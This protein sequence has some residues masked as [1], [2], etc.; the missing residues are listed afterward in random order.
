MGPTSHRLTTILKTF[1]VL[2]LFLWGN[3]V[4]LAL[5]QTPGA[6]PPPLHVAE[7]SFQETFVS[8]NINCHQGYAWDG[9]NHYGITTGQLYK[10]DTNWNLVASNMNVFAN[11]PSLIHLGDGDYYNGTLYIVAEDWQSCANYTNQSIVTYNSTT[12][13]PL[14]QYDV[15][16]DAHEVSGLCVVPQSG[17][18]GIIY[19][20]SYC[21]G[22]RIWEYD[23][24]T[25][26]L[27]GT[28]PL[29]QDLLGLQGICSHN[30]MF[31]LSQDGGNIYSMDTNGNVAVIYTSNLSGSHEGLKYVDGAIRIL[32]DHGTGHKC[33]H[34]IS[35]KC[36]LFSCPVSATGWMV[37]GGSTLAGPW[38]SI[39][40][41]SFVTNGAILSMVTQIPQG[42]LGY[43]Q[44]EQ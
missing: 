22:S 44:L 42:N 25:I 4:S 38:Q 2:G 5:G 9:T 1:P 37:V 33:I 36:L 12:L 13:Q 8:P 30:G 35:E 26:A 17:S 24:A 41:G 19:V 6:L 20:T 43:F 27:V 23:L 10:F 15:S 11:W 3:W 31:Y 29:S 28:L 7:A 40:C 16:A 39:S 32:I 21:D 14:N 34:Y 18:N